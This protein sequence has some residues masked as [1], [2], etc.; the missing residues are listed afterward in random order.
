MAFRKKA[1]YTFQNLN[2]NTSA[3]KNKR[4]S[5]RHHRHKVTP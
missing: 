1:A 3:S 5:S 4:A 2:N